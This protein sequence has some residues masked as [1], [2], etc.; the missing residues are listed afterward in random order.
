MGSDG[1]ILPIRSNFHF[2]GPAAD[3]LP[4]LI[5]RS[6]LHPLCLI[7]MFVLDVLEM[8]EGEKRGLL[9][10]DCVVGCAKVSLNLEPN[11]IIYLAPCTSCFNEDCSHQVAPVMPSMHRPPRDPTPFILFGV[12]WSSSVPASQMIY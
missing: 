5:F 1:T 3:S 12:S 7:E 6:S 4:L 11:S 2:P 9:S 8:G 10:W